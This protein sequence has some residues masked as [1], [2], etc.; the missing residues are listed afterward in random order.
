[1]TEQTLYCDN[2]DSKPRD[3]D[4]S[5]GYADRWEVIEPDFDS[6]SAERC[7]EYAANAGFD[8]DMDIT[9]R[10]ALVEALESLG[11][12]CFDDESDELLREAFLESVTSGDWANIDEWR[13]ACAADWRDNGRGDPMMNYAYPITLRGDASKAATKLELASL[14]LTLVSIDDETHLAL[15]GGG[16]DLSAEICE[17]Y[18]LLGQ[19]PPVHF[20]KVPRMGGTRYS[21]AFLATLVESCEIAQR[22]AQNTI[23]D[24][25][26]LAADPEYSEAPAPKEHRAE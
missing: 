15:T 24:L 3:F 2:V 12:A 17:A 4:F 18:I 8:L 1:M 11:I 9:E 16:M 13:E 26:H 21:Q 10:E 5:Q 6:W 25:K 23:D 22:W 19:R 20:C 14:P 7:V